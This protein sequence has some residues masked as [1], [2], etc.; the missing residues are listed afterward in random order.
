[1]EFYL[2]NA[3]VTGDIRCHAKKLEIIRKL[4][5]DVRQY[6]INEN[7][8]MPRGLENFD[9]VFEK[10]PFFRGDGYN[11][12]FLGY[13]LIEYEKLPIPANYWR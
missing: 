2:K 10:L 13:T 8:P 6:Q 9:I 5:G 4:S 12:E 7:K 3:K 1:M 11:S